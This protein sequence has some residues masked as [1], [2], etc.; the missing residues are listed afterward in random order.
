MS[1]YESLHEQYGTDVGFN[2]D[3]NKSLQENIIGKL[4]AE[5]QSL[6]LQLS[7]KDARI[8]QL[9]SLVID[10]YRRIE[11]LIDQA[12]DGVDDV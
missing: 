4:N 5:K 7:I 6:E 12:D 11:R 2:I 9:E 10:L 3:Y 8:N 1:H